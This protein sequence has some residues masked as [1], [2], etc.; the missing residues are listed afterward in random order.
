MADRQTM[1]DRLGH[2]GLG[3][4]NRI[5]DRSAA[6][7]VGSNSR[8]KCA[9]C[10]VRMGGLDEV[11]FEYVEEPAVIEQVRCALGQKMSP[12][13]QHVLAAEAMDDFRGAAGIGE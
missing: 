11:S 4:L 2:I 7:E 8:R 13:D 3:R 9:S 12:L 5:D 1:A 10:A 6:C